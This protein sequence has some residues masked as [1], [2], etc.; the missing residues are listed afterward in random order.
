VNILQHLISFKIS[1][2]SA[3]DH[4]KLALQINKA[5]ELCKAAGIKLAYQS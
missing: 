1:G 4:K 3:D 5:A 2:K